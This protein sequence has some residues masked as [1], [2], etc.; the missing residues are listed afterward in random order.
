MLS[1]YIQATNLSKSASIVHGFFGRQGGVSKGIYASLN[2]GVG[3]RD[4]AQDVQKNRST[5]AQILGGDILHTVHQ[6][7]SPNVAVLQSAWQTPPQA[8]AIVTKQKGCTI[9]VLTADCVPVL[10]ADEK[11]GVIGCAHAGW[12]GALSGVI[13]NTV[14]V[15]EEQGAHRENIFAA[16]GPCICQESYEVGEELR[17]HFLQQTGENTRYFI[18]GAEG[19]YWFD[20]GGYALAQCE[21]AAID[22]IEWLARDTYALEADYFSYRRTTHRKEEDYGRQVSAIALR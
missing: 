7:H 3:S 1:P 5:V 10:F 11:A 13:E 2:V 18:D 22:S 16:I 21:R 20:I 14:A 6:V 4:V 8:D 15:M 19:K 17:Q 12:K 9:G